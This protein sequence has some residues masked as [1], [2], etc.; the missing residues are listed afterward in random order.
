[1]NNIIEEVYW[2]MD[3]SRKKADGTRLHPEMPEKEMIF[4]SEKALAMLLNNEV[5]F[6]NNHWWEKEWPEEAKQTFS[7]N[8][9]CN[10]VFAWGC[11]DAEEITYD[12]L[13]DLYDH[14]VKDPQWGSAIWCIKKRKL[15]PQRPVLISIEKNGIWDLSSMGLADNSE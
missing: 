12:E 13:K 10:D 7:I 4:E 8:C 1:M 14:F 3:W 5:V 11:A 15:M 9:N 2:E 6:L